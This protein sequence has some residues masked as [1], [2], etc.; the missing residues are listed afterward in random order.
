MGCCFSQQNK[1][2]RT[3]RES[4]ID[5]SSL[6]QWQMISQPYMKWHWMLMVSPTGFPMARVLILS[7]SLKRVKHIWRKRYVHLVVFSSLHVSHW[8]HHCIVHS[9]WL[10]SIFPNLHQPINNHHG[11]HSYHHHGRVVSEFNHLQ[12]RSHPCKH[13]SHVHRFYHFYLCILCMS[14]AV[15]HHVTFSQSKSNCSPLLVIRVRC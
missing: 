15:Y 2:C 10:T 7:M 1:V 12:K 9:Q 13:L 3:W 11:L 4:T 8:S 6:K 5:I 14:S